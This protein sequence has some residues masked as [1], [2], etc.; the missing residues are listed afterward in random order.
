MFNST[1]EIQQKNKRTKKSLT[2]FLFIFIFSK[3]VTQFSHRVFHLLF[4]CLHFPVLIMNDEGWTTAPD[5][6]TYTS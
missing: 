2:T 5:N 6:T 1:N 3:I 4:V